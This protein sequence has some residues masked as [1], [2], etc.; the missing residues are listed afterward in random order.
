MEIKKQ[1]KILELFCGTKSFSK[2]AE[3]REH[4]EHCKRELEFLKKLFQI[5]LDIKSIEINN[6][7]FY[8]RIKNN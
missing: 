4:L 1:L 6:D 5:I 7:D 3:E 8:Y 2:V